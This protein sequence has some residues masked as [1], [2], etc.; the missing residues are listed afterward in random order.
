MQ[1]L[2]KLPITVSSVLR[3]LLFIALAAIAHFPNP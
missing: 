3:V 1:A 2:N